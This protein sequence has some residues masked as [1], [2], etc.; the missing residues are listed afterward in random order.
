MCIIILLSWNFFSKRRKEEQRRLNQQTGMK[1]FDSVA[2]LHEN[3]ELE[4]KVMIMI[5]RGQPLISN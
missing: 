4:G 2:R 3:I 1:A 5:L